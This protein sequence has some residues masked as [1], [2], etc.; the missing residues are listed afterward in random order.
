V[1]P[2]PEYDPEDESPEAQLFRAEAESAE[3][4]ARFCEQR[5]RSLFQTLG[6]GDRVRRL[7]PFLEMRRWGLRRH[8]PYGPA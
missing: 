6:A 4:W 7:I 1:P 2:L 5:I 8:R 3:R